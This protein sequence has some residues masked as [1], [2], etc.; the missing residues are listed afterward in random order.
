MNCPGPGFRNRGRGMMGWCLTS[1][2][3]PGATVHVCM[4]TSLHSPNPEQSTE[5]HRLRPAQNLT[6]T[7][8]VLAK[9]AWKDFFLFV[10]APLIE[11]CQ[12]SQG[13]LAAS[14]GDCTWRRKKMACYLRGAIK[15]EPTLFSA[16]S[17]PG[18]SYAEQQINPGVTLMHMSGLTTVRLSHHHLDQ[19]G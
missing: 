9:G 16:N 6:E 15:W 8:S 14:E 17:K 11:M 5:D 3:V 1:I 18:T 19:L 10:A 12:A 7:A 13:Q 4:Q 2:Q